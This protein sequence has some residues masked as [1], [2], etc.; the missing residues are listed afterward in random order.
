MILFALSEAD[1]HAAAYPIAQRQYHIE[2]VVRNFIGFA[3]FV[4]ID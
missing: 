3:V 2:V 4:L 1:T